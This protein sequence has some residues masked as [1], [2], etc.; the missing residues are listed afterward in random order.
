MSQVASS[1][2][3]V[4]SELR[5]CRERCL[6]SERSHSKRL[7]TLVLSSVWLNLHSFYFIYTTLY[8]LSCR[9]THMK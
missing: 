9:V 8:T 7:M 2:Y 4:T 5:K 1:R 6:I 3:N